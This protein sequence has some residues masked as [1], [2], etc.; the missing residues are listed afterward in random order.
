MQKEVIARFLRWSPRMWMCIKL[1]R[2]FRQQQTSIAHNPKYL[3]PSRYVLKISHQ[4]N[5]PEEYKQL[6]YLRSIR[7]GMMNLNTLWKN[8]PFVIEFPSICYDNFFNKF[9]IFFTFV[10]HYLEIFENIDPRRNMIFNMF[11]IVEAVIVIW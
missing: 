10:I 4:K 1:N 5:S 6:I 8:Y 11:I 2:R 9:A 3:L 7:R